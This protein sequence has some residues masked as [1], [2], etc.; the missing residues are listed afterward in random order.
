M[1]RLVIEAG[2][3]F[4]WEH[5]VENRDAIIGITCFGASAPG[6][7]MLEKYGFTPERIVKKAMELLKD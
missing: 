6:G 7:T 5:Y 2:T 3:P 4:G 1:P